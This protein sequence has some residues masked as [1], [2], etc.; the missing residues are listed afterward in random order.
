MR[1]C[2]CVREEVRYE[3][4]VSEINYSSRDSTTTNTSLSKI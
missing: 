4:I 2:V 1:V 3:D